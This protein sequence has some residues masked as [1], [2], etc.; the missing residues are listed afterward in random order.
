M[1]TKSRVRKKNGKP[2]KYQP[3]PKG[4][5]KTK[6]KKILAMIEEQQKI[7][8][9]EKESTQENIE[10][11]VIIEDNTVDIIEN[12]SIETVSD[13]INESENKEI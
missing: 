2:V 9:T 13:D 10:E 7:L 3:K 11:A 1:G 12:D 4:I 6:M 8:A 5:S